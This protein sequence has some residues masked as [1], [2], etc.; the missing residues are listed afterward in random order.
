M[1]KELNQL[2]NYPYACMEQT[3]SKLK[4]FLMEDK[5]RTK[6]GQTPK[7]SKQI[8]SLLKRLKTGQK[9][10]GAWGWWENSA[11]NTW[12][13][14]YILLSIAK[15]QQSGYEFKG[16][17]TATTYLFAMLPSLKGEDLLTTLTTLSALKTKIP[18]AEYLTKLEKEELNFTQKLKIIKL[19]QENNLPYNIDLISKEKKETLLGNYYW[20]KESSDWYDNSTNATL[21]VYNILETKDSSNAWLANI[22]NYFLELKAQQKWKNTIE[23]ACILETI[24]PAI[25]KENNN[26]LQASSLQLTSNKTEII[27]SFPYHNKFTTAGKM[28]ITKQGSTP[29]YFTAFQRKWNSEPIAKN[30]LYSIQTHFEQENKVVQKLKAGIATELVIEIDVKKKTQYL[31]IE[32]PLPA[33]CTYADNK[34][35]NN[36]NESHREYFK[37]KTLIY[38]EQLKEGKH[39]F[40]INLQARYSGTYTI[41]PVKVESMYFPIFYGRNGIKKIKID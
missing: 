9:T 8:K 21:L 6:L 11:E 40:T 7:N 36:Y 39:S 5:I 12:M 25:L 2:Q 23:T 3:A 33:G 13:T 26:K 17:E 10:N 22:R 14:N 38:C 16:V 4:G 20:S 34:Y 27:N 19:K 1:I 41:N 28:Q 29:V 15:A 31:M 32:V 30:D 18:Y 24:L 37:E 35:N